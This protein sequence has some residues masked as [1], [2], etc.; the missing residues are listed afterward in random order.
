MLTKDT[1]E[2]DTVIAMEKL[3]WQREKL[4]LKGHFN[5]Y[6]LCESVSISTNTG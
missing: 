5:N 3:W 2:I 1:L 4:L 6:Q